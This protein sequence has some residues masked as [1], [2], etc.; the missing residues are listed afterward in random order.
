MYVAIR[1]G[2]EHKFLGGNHD[3]PALCRKHPNYLADYRYLSRRQSVLRERRF[4]GEP[5]RSRPQGTIELVAPETYEEQ[6]LSGVAT[7][8]D[9]SD[10]YRIGS[11]TK[12][13]VND[14][15]EP[16]RGV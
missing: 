3:D 9:K 11:P 2:S 4:N 14:A 6:F 12:F 16:L 7:E 5:A 13:P 15:T 8:L 10:R 1:G